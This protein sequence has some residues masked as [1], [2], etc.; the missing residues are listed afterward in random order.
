MPY[1]IVSQAEKE[2][3]KLAQADI[4]HRVSYS[5]WAS[6]MV[7][8]PPRPTDVSEL[9]SFLG[10]IN[11]YSKFIKDFSSKLHPLYELLSDKAKWLWSEA[12][13]AAVCLGQRDSFQ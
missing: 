7:H 8:V 13:E 1:L 3:E 4:L 12:R 2:Y 6:P 10:M 5:N 9:S 11:Y